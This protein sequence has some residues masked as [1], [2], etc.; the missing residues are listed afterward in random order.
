MYTS[1]T[2]RYNVKIEFSQTLLDQ[3]PHVKPV[4]LSVAHQEFKQSE[5]LWAEFD[6]AKFSTP[7]PCG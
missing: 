5:F 2:F 3:W 6:V 4:G 1:T 7:Q